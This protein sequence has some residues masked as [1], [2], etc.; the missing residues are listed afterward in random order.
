MAENA[1]YRFLLI[2]AFSLPKES[3][4]LHRPVEG[5]KEARLMNYEQWRRKKIF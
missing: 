2:Q 4:F 3:R 5:P 1:K